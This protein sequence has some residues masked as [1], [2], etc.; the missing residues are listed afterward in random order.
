MLWSR[1]EFL[2]LQ[3]RSGAPSTVSD[4]SGSWILHWWAGVCERE[5]VSFDRSL[6]ESGLKFEGITSNQMKGCSMQTPSLLQAE[7][8]LGSKSQSLQTCVASY[9]WLLAS[10]M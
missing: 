4:L 1:F 2:L 3:I 5:R 10:K 9:L 6:L 8:M 7:A